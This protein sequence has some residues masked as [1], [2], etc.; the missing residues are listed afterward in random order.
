[1]NQHSEQ[2]LF[3]ELS[4]YTLAHGDPSFIHQHIV[5]AYAAQNADKNTKPI[6]IA[7]GLIGLYLHIAHGYTGR[8][9]QLAHMQL[10]RHRKTWP[11]FDLPVDRGAVSVADVMKAPP[12]AERD[13]AIE[14]WAASVWEAFSMN[15]S[16]V[17]QLVSSE[18]PYIKAKGR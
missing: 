2:E 6:G 18:L 10:A 7:F 1:M 15:H 5:D 17:A 4:F 3:N 14:K 9:V 12:G 16:Q 13:Q 11:A 8:E